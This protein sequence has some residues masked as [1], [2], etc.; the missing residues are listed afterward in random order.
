[1]YVYQERS[2]KKKKKQ[3]KSSTKIVQKK[4]PNIKLNRHLLLHFQS[5]FLHRFFLSRSLSLLHTMSY[6]LNLRPAF[7]YFTFYCCCCV[8]FFLHIFLRLSCFLL[9]FFFSSYFFI[10]CCFVYSFFF[11]YSVFF[12][13]RKIVARQMFRLDGFCSTACLCM[14]VLLISRHI[15]FGFGYS[16]RMKRLNCVWGKRGKKNESLTHRRRTQRNTT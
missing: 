3:K 4:E 10:W 13:R 14:C 11:A 16:F 7:L 9:L 5:I 12:L 15:M 8:C 6:S 1:M 2:R